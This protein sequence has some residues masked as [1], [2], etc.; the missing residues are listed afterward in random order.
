MNHRTMWSSFGMAVVAIKSV[1]DF[2]EKLTSLAMITITSL[3][4]G[5]IGLAGRSGLGVAA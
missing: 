5:M 3:I 2:W 4:I 1:G